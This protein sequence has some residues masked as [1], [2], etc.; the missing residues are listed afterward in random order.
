MRIRYK[1][2]REGAEPP[3]KAHID[4]AGYDLT[5]VETSYDLDGNL[6]CKTGIAVEIPKGYVGLLF[7]RSSCASKS[8]IMA[9]CVG[10]IDSGYIGEL[11]AKFKL[12]SQSNVYKP[13]QRCCQLV[14]QQIP[15]IEM[16][17]SDDILGGERG[18]GG[19]GESG[20]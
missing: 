10:V 8:V 16:V 5:A 1:I 2:V 19:Y 18:D 11:T 6:V 20:E 13:G 7:P 3:Y 17:E 4:D 15:H 14:I 9:N 12:L